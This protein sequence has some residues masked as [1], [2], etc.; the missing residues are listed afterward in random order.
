LLSSHPASDWGGAGENEAH[1][2]AHKAWFFFDTGLLALGANISL[3]LDAPV[4]TTINQ[5]LLAGDVEVGIL[6]S[7]PRLLPTGQHSLTNFD[8]V[9]LYHIFL[10]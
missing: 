10:Y 6:G 3:A 8:Y 2:L 5:C 9:S 1:L 7:S 4:T